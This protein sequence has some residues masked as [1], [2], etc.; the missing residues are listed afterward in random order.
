MSDIAI[1]K[2]G[3]KIIVPIQNELNDIIAEKLQASILKTIESVGAKGLIIDVSTLSIID[4]FMG[5]LLVDTA[6]MAQLMGCETALTGMRKEVVL[7]LVQLGLIISDINT[8]LNIEDGI[9]LL[10]R[11]IRG[12]ND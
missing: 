1:I 10:D 11:I 6:K 4:S 7:T 9:E 12:R 8:S 5:R 3:N 2:I